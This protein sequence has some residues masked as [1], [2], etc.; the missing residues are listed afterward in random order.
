M[1]MM[2]QL[3]HHDSHIS[4]GSAAFQNTTVR[5]KKETGDHFPRIET[6]AHLPR[7]ARDKG[8]RK[9]NKKLVFL[10]SRIVG[11]W[12]ER[13]WWRSTHHRSAVGSRHNCGA[14]AENRCLF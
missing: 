14:G 4:E 6:D 8:K 5:E 13:R 9:L 10:F 12:R 7:Q 11:G 2:E 1:S 3:E